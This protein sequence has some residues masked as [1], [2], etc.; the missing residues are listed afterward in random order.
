MAGRAHL[1]ATPAAP[2]CDTG[3]LSGPTTLNAVR[4]LPEPTRLASER[5][6]FYRIRVAETIQHMVDKLDASA[7]APSV[8]RA[9]SGVATAAGQGG[10]RRARPVVPPGATATREGPLP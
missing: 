10:A 8:Q 2:E 1:G 9:P 4:E 7:V 5:G 3:A 6:G